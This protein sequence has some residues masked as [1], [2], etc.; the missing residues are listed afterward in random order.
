MPRLAPGTALYRNQDYEFEKT[1][2]KR[3][4][5]R[6]IGIEFLLEENDFGFTLTA[7][8]EENTGHASSLSRNVIDLFGEC[9]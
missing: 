5:E 8:D 6:K 7:I 1:L 4:A 3:S 9:F 2:S